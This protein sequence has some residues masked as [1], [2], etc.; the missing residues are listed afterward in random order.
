MD[1]ADG[2][3]ESC[4]EAKARKELADPTEKK[5]HQKEQEDTLKGKKGGGSAVGLLTQL[6]WNVVVT[7]CKLSLICFLK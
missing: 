6:F 5:E 2:K 1:E 7:S 4:S 3:A